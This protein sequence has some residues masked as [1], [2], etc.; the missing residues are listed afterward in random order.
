MDLQQL[1]QHRNSHPDL[2]KAVD[3]SV[4][5]A[6]LTQAYDR[7]HNVVAPPH[8]IGG[9]GASRSAT[10]SRPPND[11]KSIESHISFALGYSQTRSCARRFV[12]GP[13]MLR[14]NRSPSR[15]PGSSM[16]RYVRLSPLPSSYSLA[17]AADQYWVLKFRRNRI[18]SHELA[19][20]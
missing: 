7:R 18:A 19:L 6:G 20:L 1:F 4:L 5:M 13:I 17:F 9:N 12:E 10:E 2:R 3:G 16:M 15:Q 11:G 8:K 14:C